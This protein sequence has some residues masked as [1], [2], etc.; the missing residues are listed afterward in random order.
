MPDTSKYTDEQMLL[1]SG[2]QH[3]V[4]CPRQWALIHIEQAWADNTLTADGIIKH[5]NVDD[6]Y[7]RERNATEILTLRGIR[8]VSYQLGL[9]GIADAIEVY[10][11]ADA[12]KAKKDL[13]VSMQ[14]N[15]IP[16]EYKRGRRK[17]SD[18]DRIQVAAQAIILEEML[19]IAIH[20]G[21]IFYW[22]ERR[23]E[24]FDITVKL[25]KSVRDI[26]TI[27]HNLSEQGIT[28]H[29]VYSKHCKACSLFDICEPSLATKSVHKY[30]A[31]ELYEET[32]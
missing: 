22:E 32:T 8:L 5:Q 10:P 2:I 16:V 20:T 17:A 4:F 7:R 12:P 18:C 11:N 25:R 27:M 6:P 19:D 30:L 28:P 26:S 15:I 29:A 23:R 13:L 24:V 21:A 3:Y 1:L 9:S 14:Y 31:T